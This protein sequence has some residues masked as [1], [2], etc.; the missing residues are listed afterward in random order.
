MKYAVEMG[1][2]TV[3]HI[4][5]FINIGLSIQNLIRSYMRTNTQTVR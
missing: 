1:L 2:D 3:I 5:S 4:P